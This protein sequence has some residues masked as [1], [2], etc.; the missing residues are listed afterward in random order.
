MKK[1]YLLFL[2]AL[3]TPFLV[4]AQQTPAKLK[5][6]SD[7]TYKRLTLEL[8]AINKTDQG[9]RVEY[10]AA[11]NKSGSQS[12]VM[13]SLGRLL[14][15]HDSLNT[16]KVSQILDQYGWLGEDKIGRLGN[17]TLFL[18]IQH[19]GLKT[20]Q[21]YLPMMRIAV[22]NGN[23]KPSALALMEDRVALR[24]GKKQIYGSQ[25][26]SIPDQP[27]KYYLSPLIDPEH[28]DERRAT[29][30]LGKLADYLKNWQLTWDVAEYQKQLP[31]YEEWEKRIKW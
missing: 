20:Q 17:Q 29:V 6:V 2:A 5:A 30:G 25:L 8:D 24:E 7:S 16:A 31:K 13:D 12:K 15:Y 19:A 4:N 1:R 22:K 10:M 11:F 27:G 3:L 21:K 14:R 23:A 26:S 18:V 9:L 28:V